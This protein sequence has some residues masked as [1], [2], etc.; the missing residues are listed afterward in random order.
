MKNIL[1]I[2]AIFMF[3]LL[4]IN[5]FNSIAQTDPD[6]LYLKDFRPKNIYNIP[7]TTITKG[8]FL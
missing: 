5:N 3:F 7:E 2:T 4:S 6:K 8:N 1:Y